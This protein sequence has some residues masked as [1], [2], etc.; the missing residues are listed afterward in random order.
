[1]DHKHGDEAVLRIPVVDISHTDLK[2]ATRLAE[3]VAEYGFVF[4][5]GAGLGFTAGILD[6]I[7]AMVRSAGIFT[8]LYILDRQDI[9]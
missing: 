1:M 9:V 8:C 3:A 2:T 6:D 4:V 7:F 5:N